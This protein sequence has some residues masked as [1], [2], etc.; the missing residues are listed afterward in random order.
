MQP[1]P[2]SVYGRQK[3][4]TGSSRQGGD[5]WGVTHS[6]AWSHGEAGGM[7][8]GERGHWEVWAMGM[9]RSQVPPQ[10]SCCSMELGVG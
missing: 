9:A 10:P 1:L 5:S 4:V 3:G 2:S 7:S 6:G 8:T